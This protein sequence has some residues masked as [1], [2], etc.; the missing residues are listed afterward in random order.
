MK[1]TYEMGY[2]RYDRNLRSCVPL[3]A[4][5]EALRLIIRRLD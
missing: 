4:L 5:G 2:R 1:N 3:N